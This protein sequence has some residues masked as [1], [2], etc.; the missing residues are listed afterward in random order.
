MAAAKNGNGKKVLTAATLSA[1]G[2]KPLGDSVVDAPGTPAI[3]IVGVGASAGGLEALEELFHNMPAGT[4][5]AFVVITHLHPGHESL[6]PELLARITDV[7]VVAAAQ[8]MKVQANRIYVGAPGGQLSIQG[9]V[10]QRMEEDRH[11]APKM[12]INYFL[13]SLAHDQK[14][15]AICIILSGTGTDGTLGLRDIKGESGMVMVEQPQSAQ[16]NG[17]PTSAVATGLADFILP[18]ASMPQ[19]LIEYVDAAHSGK[20]VKEIQGHVIP[21]ESM[22]DIFQ[23]LRNHTGHDFSEYKKNTIYR[24]VARRMN[25]HQIKQH[26]QYVRYLRENSH[27]IDILFKELLISVTNFFRDSEAW[28]ALLPNVKHLLQSRPQGST[29]RVWV[30]GCSS[31][32]EVF[33]LAI[34]LREC[35]DASSHYMDVQI[36][37][38]DL[39]SQSIEK[40]RTGR[41]PEGISDDLTPQ[42]LQKYFVKEEGYYRIRK[43]IREMT[44][45]AEQ[46]AIKDPPFT[47]MDIIAC[48]N[49]LIYLN[50]EI[51][52]ELL[53]LFHYALKPGGLLFLGASETIGSF[54]DL[55]EPLDKRWKIFRRREVLP[56]RASLFRF[57]TQSLAAGAVP[58]IET[59]QRGSLQKTSISRLIE[60]VLLRRFVPPCAIINRRGDIIYLHGRTGAYLEPNEGQPRNNILEM[61]RDG[62][63]I[64][65]AEAMRQCLAEDTEIIRKG[66]RVQSNGSKVSVDLTLVK[67]DQPDALSELLLVAFTPTSD[68]PVDARTETTIYETGAAA[69]E[70]VEQLERAL[71]FLRDTHQATLEDL[72]TS[73]EELEA[74]NEELQSTNEELQSSNEEL[75]TSKEEMQSLNEELTTVNTELISKVS[76]LS[77]A[78]DDMQNLLNSTKVATVFLD[79]ELLIKR[80]TDQARDLIMLRQTDIGRPISELA[81]NLQHEDL[82]ADCKNVLETLVFKEHEVQTLDGAYYLMRIMPYRTA[83]NAIDGLVLTFVDINRL[84]KAQ[85]ELR[86]MSEVFREATDPII[87]VDL[88]YRIVD[89][90]DRAVQAYGYTRDEIN[91]KPVQS[92]VPRARHEAIAALFGRCRDGERVHR[93]QWMLLNRSGHEIPILLTLTLLTGEQGNV[94]AI[95]MVTTQVRQ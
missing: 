21:T 46:N 81:S 77:Q 58:L 30:P 9:G 70:R 87:I 67:L 93:V 7:P 32:E 6:L 14:E 3:A 35:M 34:L 47:K 33:S 27:E 68:A 5:I 36:F 83:G 76:D 63:K 43:E 29:L 51:Q 75:E 92:V 80:F 12:P 86:H 38:T 15:R 78:N 82:A 90:N 69:D 71:S 26:D 60:Q 10:L 49:L 1:A 17:M 57:P 94:D 64:D 40:A 37:G 48:R 18:P 56:D 8:G 53:P 25:V 85:K 88:E 74:T 20:D 22:Q 91:G 89:L 59:S 66:I 11:T 50:A 2:D 13:R 31:G 41:Y 61:A 19:K 62:L 72:E 55:F 79:G 24:R 44:I 84:K 42:R 23:L 73:N 65:L 95:A 16:Y 52:K 4:G 39:D 54:T 45:F 28:D